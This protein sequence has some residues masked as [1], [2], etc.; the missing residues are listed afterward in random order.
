[1]EIRKCLQ[2]YPG[3]LF[4]IYIYSTED[5]KE[6][7]RIV[8]S[9]LKMIFKKI[10]GGEDVIITESKPGLYDKT[11]E[12]YYKSDSEVSFRSTGPIIIVDLKKEMPKG[13]I[14]NFLR[15]AT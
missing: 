12:V 5:K 10:L 13:K 15:A 8:E 7:E 6:A 3:V 11:I 9:A 1:M 14:E 4:I 2:R